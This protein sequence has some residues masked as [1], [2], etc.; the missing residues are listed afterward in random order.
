MVRYAI[1]GKHIEEPR[2]VTCTS[3]RWLRYLIPVGDDCGLLY[4][5]VNAA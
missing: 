5:G 1:A 2:W 3:G 4:E